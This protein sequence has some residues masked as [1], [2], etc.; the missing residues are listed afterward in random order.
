MTEVPGYTWGQLRGYMFS[1]GSMAL[2]CDNCGA[3]VGNEVTH[4]EW[5]ERTGL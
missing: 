3:V 2:F 5:H 4:T 1:E